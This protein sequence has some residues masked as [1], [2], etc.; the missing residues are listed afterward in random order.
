MYYIVCRFRRLSIADGEN[1]IASGVSAPL[2][3]LE[4]MV[5]RLAHDEDLPDHA[6]L[7]CKYFDLIVG[8]GEGGWIAMMLGRLEMPV[9]RCIEVYNVIRNSLHSLRDSD[10]RSRTDE[11]ERLLK[12]LIRRETGGLN[13][14]GELLNPLEGEAAP[15]S[16]LSCKTAILTSTAGN[17]FLPTPFRTYKVRDN[18]TSNCPV[19]MA[20]RAAAA[21]P[22]HFAPI[23]IN[24]QLLVSAAHFGDSNPIEFALSEAAT[25]FGKDRH[26]GYIVSLGAGHPGHIFFNSSLATS[27][28]NATVRIAQ[29]SERK[30]QEVARRLSQSGINVYFRFNVE[31]GLQWYTQEQQNLRTDVRTHAMAYISQHSVGDN[32]DAVVRKLRRVDDSQQ[33]RQ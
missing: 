5:Q 31:Q 32:L 14:D 3:V 28:S 33:H 25:V 2:V 27:Y 7:P 11:F 12:D 18:R 24:T 29:D 1:S 13:P 8:S 15:T 4:E 30:A 6:T 23:E 9:S 19:W 16:P 10:E 17:I 20:I 21:T 26:I 22:S